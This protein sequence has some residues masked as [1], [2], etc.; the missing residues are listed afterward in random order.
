[1]TTPRSGALVPQLGLHALPIDGYSYR[2]ARLAGEGEAYKLALLMHTQ[3]IREYR[4]VGA[5]RGALDECTLYLDGW[6][7]GVMTL[8]H[9][10]KRAAGVPSDG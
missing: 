8:R 7:S 1:M 3:T 6:L 2:L 10:M 9:A 4:L 5:H